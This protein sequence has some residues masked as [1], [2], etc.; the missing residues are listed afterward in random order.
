[1]S[2]WKFEIENLHDMIYRCNFWTNFFDK[3]KQS[4]MCTNNFHK[5]YKCNQCGKLFTHVGYMRRHIKLFMKVAK[6]SN[7]NLVE[8]HLLKLI[9]WAHTYIEIIHSGHKDFKCDSCGKLFSHSSNSRTHEKKFINI[10][11]TGAKLDKKAWVQVL[12]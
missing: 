4:Q 11:S 2:K 8:N 12:V 6:I 9:F 3:K 1:M 10:I 5:A 7:V